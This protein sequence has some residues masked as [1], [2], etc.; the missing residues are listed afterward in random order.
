MRGRKAM[1]KHLTCECTKFA[2]FLVL[3]LT[4]NFNREIAEENLN[5]DVD[6]KFNCREVN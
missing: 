5:D 4:S 2:H 6:E 1:E 3:L